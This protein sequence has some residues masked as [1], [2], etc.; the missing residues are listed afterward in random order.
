M[1]KKKEEGTSVYITQ[2]SYSS[3]SGVPLRLGQRTKLTSGSSVTMTSL[4]SF[5]F[6]DGKIS[7]I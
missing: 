5:S 7:R 1:S 6:C 4:T 2:S 3:V